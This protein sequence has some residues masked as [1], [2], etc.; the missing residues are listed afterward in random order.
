MAL[1]LKE[2]LFGKPL[3]TEEELVEQVGPTKAIP[4]LGLDALAS[5]SYGPEAAMTI[6]LPLGILASGYIGWITICIVV[7]LLAVFVSYLQTIPAYPQGGGSFTVAKENLG[8][9][10]G[11]LAASALCTDYVLNVAVAISA[12][13]GAM[14]SAWPPLLPYTVPLC[15]GILALL[16]F[17]NLRGVRTAGLVFMLPTYLFISCLAITVL[18]GMVK[19]VLDHGQ[20][21]PVTTPP[22]INPAIQTASVWLLLRS[23]ASGSTALTGVEAVS[24]AVP[25]FRRPSVK[26]AR[27]TLTVLIGLLAFLLCG[28]AFLI[29]GYHINAMPPGQAG[30]QSIISQIVGAVAGRNIFYYVTIGSVL[31][32][33]TLSANTS[34]ADFPRVCHML[35]LDEYL[36]AEFAH[37]GSR[38]VYSSGIVVLASLAAVLL[39][40]FRGI[41][42]RL[43][44][45]FAIGAFTAFTL[46]Q[47]GMVIHWRRSR[48]P[49]A[50]RSMVLNAIGATATACTLVIITISKFRAGAWLVVLVIPLLIYFL[51]RIRRYNSR[52]ERET[53]DNMPLE[54]SDLCEPIVVIP[55]K[56]L[57]RVARKALRLALTL[58][59]EIHVVQILSEEMRTEDLTHEWRT[60]VEEPVQGINRKPPIL[61][62]RPSAYREFFGP[63]LDYLKEVAQ[64]NPGRHIA[65]LVPELVEKH[66]YD[67]FLRHRATVLKAVL[68]LRGGPQI[69]II[70]APWYVYEEV[71]P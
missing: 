33:L 52:V 66:W 5:S 49:H 56:R 47:L 37:R 11:L 13:V 25:S 68:I 34:F 17:V 63:L 32:A 65:V 45:L 44:P 48:E 70:T 64:K 55:M 61:V 51:L 7:V 29:H 6:L 43:I 41:T 21:V 3:R 28:I 58:T 9:F 54:V 38:L 8:T 19:V 39:L 26:L 31:L 62:V 36:P 50:R 69:I 57:D 59:S 24:N 60:L 42:D 22:R 46:S 1:H 20:P 23:F 71:K 18:I 53:G 30:Y 27:K 67:F 2:L 4:V 35:A 15:L 12:G 14:V 40:I 16:T 10:A